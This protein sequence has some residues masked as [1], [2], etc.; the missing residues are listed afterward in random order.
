[1]SEP[2]RIVGNAIG[3]DLLLAGSDAFKHSAEELAAAQ[4]RWQAAGAEPATLQWA[5]ELAAFAG[6]WCGR[7]EGEADVVR[8]NCLWTTLESALA[9]G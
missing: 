8:S 3:V 9:G 1:M 5:R 6:W 7:L 4:A 2:K